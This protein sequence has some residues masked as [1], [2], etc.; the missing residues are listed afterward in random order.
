MYPDAL[1]ICCADANFDI[2]TGHVMRAIALAEAWRREGGKAV[3]LTKSNP[4]LQQRAAKS[5]AEIHELSGNGDSL[6]ALEAIQR[7]SRSFAAKRCWITLD[8]YQFDDAFQKS[9]K[10]LKHPLLVIDDYAHLSHY[11]ADMILNQNAGAELMSYPADHATLLLGTDYVLLRDEFLSASRAQEYAVDQAHLLVTM[12]GVDAPNATQTI[13]N[14]LNGI[15]SNSISIRVLI[16][17]ANP[18][19][20]SFEQLTKFDLSNAELIVQADN[21]SEHYL[22]SN[23][24]IAAAGTT[25]WELCYFGIPSMLV[26]IAD[27]QRALAVHLAQTG[28]AI[29]LGWFSE[30]DALNLRRQMVDFIHDKLLR[31]RMSERAK[32]LVDGRGGNLLLHEM[33]RISNAGAYINNQSELIHS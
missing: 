15:E 17:R 13:L 31:R 1:L 12:G 10:A 9:I 25:S 19:R 18:H 26:Q 8:G 2:G 4:W 33:R 11:T 6:E 21:M 24:A 22:W 29:N 20:E 32:N 7:I 16:G 5:F 28:A 23:M 27:N 14:A 3:L 30:L